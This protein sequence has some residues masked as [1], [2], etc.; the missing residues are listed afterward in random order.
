MDEN[1]EKKTKEKKKMGL[2]KKIL[3]VLCIIIVVLA[4]VVGIRYSIITDICTKYENTGKRE[5]YYYRA[6][7]KDTEIELWRKGNLAKMVTRQVNGDGVITFWKNSDTNQQVTVFGEPA[8]KYNDESDT[9]ILDRMP[10]SSF[11][12]DQPEI[13]FLFAIN[14][15]IYIGTDN[16]NGKDC[17]VLS[18][19]DNKDYIEKETGIILYGESGNNEYRKINYS[20]GTVTDE[21]VKKP[22]KIQ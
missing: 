15:M 22:D 21:Q 10:A 20:I 19:E 18:M 11:Y 9:I 8:E 5:N 16:Y 12:V 1:N 13:R 2:G 4:I 14:P 6:E 17:Y 7:T 3:I